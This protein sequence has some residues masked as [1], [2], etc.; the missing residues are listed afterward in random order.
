LYARIEDGD[1]V[2]DTAESARNDLAFLKAVVDDRGPLPWIFGAHLLAVGV[3]FGASFV[4]TWAIEAGRVP[5]PADW[6]GSS[7]LLGLIVWAPVLLV[8]MF[9]GARQPA[10]GPSGFVFAAMFGVVGAMC[11]AT[12]AVIKI[13]A[14]QTGDASIS[15]IWL[16][17]LFVIYGGAWSIIAI[18]RRRIWLAAVALGS[19]LF[20]AAAAATV[21]T[22]EIQLVAAAGLLLLVGAPGAIIVLAS[23]KLALG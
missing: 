3:I 14:Y 18:V 6:A 8:L 10:P 4:L 16:P 21:G 13:A 1:F 20:G 11:A 12:V 23:R 5:W 2:T 15:A 19:F 22:A 9:L 17:F 7:W